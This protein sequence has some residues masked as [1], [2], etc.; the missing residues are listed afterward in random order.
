MNTII[1]EDIKNLPIIEKMCTLAWRIRENARLT[2]TGKTKVGA[3]VYSYEDE[4]MFSGC[5]VEHRFRSHD[6]HAEVNAISSLVVA[7]TKTFDM[8]LIVALR[9]K[10]TPCGSCMDW[11]MEVS[12]PKCKIMFQGKPDGEICVYTAAELMPHYPF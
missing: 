12:G 11:I 2:S 8:V 1:A 3:V 4:K 10:F 9:D 6:I 7:G 5:N